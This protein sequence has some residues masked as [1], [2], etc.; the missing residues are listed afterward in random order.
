M[1]C[2]EPNQRREKRRSAEQLSP[3]TGTLSEPQ[4]NPPGFLV[5]NPSKGLPS[6]VHKTFEEAAAEAIRLAKIYHNH[7]FVVMESK[8]H[9]RIKDA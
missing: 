1:F 4:V 7:N 9:V 8:G 2:K 5:W 6:M 3:T